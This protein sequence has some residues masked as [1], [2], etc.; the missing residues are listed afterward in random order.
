[1]TAGSR[2]FRLSKP[3]SR[4]QALGLIGVAVNAYQFRAVL[5][6]LSCPGPDPASVP[7]RSQAPAWGSGDGVGEPTVSRTLE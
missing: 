6:S 4:N 7:E 2:R 3:V 1:M 5:G